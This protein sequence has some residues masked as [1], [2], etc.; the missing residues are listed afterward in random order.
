MMPIKTWM[1]ATALSGA[2]VLSLMTG[3][4]TRAATTVPGVPAAPIFRAVAPGTR[5]TLGGWAQW[6]SP[7]GTNS[8]AAS[9]ITVNGQPVTAVLTIDPAPLQSLPQTVPV[10]QLGQVPSLGNVPS[11]PI[12]VLITPATHWWIEPVPES[13]HVNGNGSGSALI[14]YAMVQ[15]TSL[16]HVVVAQRLCLQYIHH[17]RSP[18]IPIAPMRHSPF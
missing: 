17:G 10:G 7:P 11:G 8:H 1:T 6:V 2:A 18:V 16:Q 4:G 15:T 3:T 5:Q 9:V 14:A 12:T 13:A